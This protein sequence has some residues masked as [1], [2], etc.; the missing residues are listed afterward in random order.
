VEDILTLLIDIDTILEPNP[1]TVADMV[2]GIYTS[3][4]EM[5]D[6]GSEV[7][8]N[9]PYPA[10]YKGI[11]VTAALP[12]NGSTGL[13][14]PMQSGNS[15]Y[16]VYNTTAANSTTT[17]PLEQQ[18]SLIVYTW[19][20]SPLNTSSPERNA[21]DTLVVI[22]VNNGVYAAAQMQT[23]LNS[24]SNAL[25]STAKRQYK[26]RREESQDTFKL[27]EIITTISKKNP[28]DAQKMLDLFGMNGQ[29]GKAKHDPNALAGVRMKAKEIFEKHKTE[30]PAIHS[31]LAKLAH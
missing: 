26:P 21:A 19:R 1:L 29:Y 6:S 30:I 9:A 28:Q 5:L 23:C 4:K 22:L 2:Y 25:V 14:L 27:L 8:T 31:Y 13:A 10:T 15:S 11:N 24:S 17:L 12:A 18:N 16:V 7:Y 20:T 3:V